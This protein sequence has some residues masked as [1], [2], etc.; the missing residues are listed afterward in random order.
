MTSDQIAD[1][2]KVNRA[3]I[4][5]DLAVLVM[6][7]YLEAK[8]KVGYFP[9]AGLRSPIIGLSRLENIKVRDVQGVPIVISMNATVQDAVILF[10]LENVESLIVTDQRGSLAGMVSRK[11]LLKVTLGNQSAPTMPVSL[12]MTRQPKI[13][14]VG[15]DESV[16]SAAKKLMQH[17]VGVLP[18]VHI[19]SGE[20]GLEIIEPVG[21]V[22]KTTMTQVLLNLATETVAKDDM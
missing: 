8:P 18:V 11:D 6:I 3:T 13:V 7:G 12:V 21:G 22:S 19:K 16:L 1:F 9:G 10:F 17:E 14:T 4:R 5:S 20:D 15:P 2:L